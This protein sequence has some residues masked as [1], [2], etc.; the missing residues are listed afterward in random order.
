MHIIRIV[1]A[2]RSSAL[3][4]AIG[5]LLTEYDDIEILSEISERSKIKASVMEHRPDM[6]LVDPEMSSLNLDEMI[7]S[8]TS[9]APE[10]LFVVVTTSSSEYLSDAVDSAAHGYV[11]LDATGDEVV[12]TLRTIGGGQVV[13]AGPEIETL[14]DLVDAVSDETAPADDPLASLSPRE[15]EVANYVGIGLSNREIAEQLDLSENTIKVHLRN[16]FQKTGA[17]NRNRLAA[18][19]HATH[20]R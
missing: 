8:V 7:E 15:K 12:R 20:D 14:S 10:L 4:H 16:V 5:L 3:A 11:S 1:I 18:Q 19:I 17:V 2:F 13:A 6:L 9:A